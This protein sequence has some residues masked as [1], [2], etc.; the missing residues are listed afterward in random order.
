[1]KNSIPYVS[2]TRQFGIL[3]TQPENKHLQSRENK[4]YQRDE[5]RVWTISYDY[6]VDPGEL[7]PIVDSYEHMR[8]WAGRTERAVTEDSSSVARYD[9][10]GPGLRWRWIP[11]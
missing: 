2:D 4:N 3:A 7:F 6:R 5:V 9:T 10:G 11:A 8:W 1:M